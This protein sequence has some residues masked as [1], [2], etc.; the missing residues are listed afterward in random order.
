MALRSWWVSLWLFSLI[1]LV[2][3]CAAPAPAYAREFPARYDLH[4][5]KWTSVYMPGVDWRLLKAQCYQES[6]LNPDAVSPVGAM[7]LCQFMPATWREAQQ[8][9]GWPDDASAFAPALSVQ[10]SAWYMGRMRR[11]WSSP[12]PEWDRH[13]LAMAS[14]NAGAGNILKAQQR[15]NGAL[16]YG[17]II[18]CLPDVTGHHSRETIIYV[19][20]IWDFYVIIRLGGG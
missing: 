19:T 6:L 3:S 18:A 20:R 2:G 12:R 17:E 7:G 4:F 8:A 5:R 9:L 14:Y 13:S 1:L 10:A 16:L 11:F 15:C